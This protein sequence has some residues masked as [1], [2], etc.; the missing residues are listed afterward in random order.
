MLSLIL[1]FCKPNSH[2]KI[3]SFLL[4]EFLYVQS[5]LCSDLSSEGKEVEKLVEDLGWQIEA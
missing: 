1:F 5:L 3:S 2:K 4:G